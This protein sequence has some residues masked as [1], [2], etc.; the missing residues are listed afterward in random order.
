[1]KEY[2]RLI[3]INCTH[4]LRA[5]LDC[6]LKICPQPSM[7][8]YAEMSTD[9]C[10]ICMMHREDGLCALQAELGEESLPEVC[11]LYPRNV[12]RLTDS[13][14]C[15]CSNSCEEVVEL[16]MNCK[17]TLWFEEI[18]LSVDPEFEIDITS[19]KLECCKKSISMIQD[20]SLLLPER[21]INLGNFLCGADFFSN[22][23]PDH[24]SL[25][26]QVLQVFDKYF[27]YSSSISDYCKT[28]QSYFSIEGKEKLSEEDLKTIAEKYLS[29]SEHLEAILPDWQLLFEQLIVNHMFYNNFPYTDPQETVNDAYLSLVITY[30]FL[31]FNILGFMSDKTDLQKLVDFFAAMFRLIEHSDFEYAAV[32]LFKEEKYPV[33]DGI[34][35]LLRIRLSNK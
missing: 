35:Q 31:R 25:A 30:S 28:S 18:T 2:Y 8:C 27:E 6:A 14:E 13:S 15:S 10:G 32:N 1:M 26:F 21:F 12:K 5:K 3:G 7:E 17:E 19:K 24:L 33:Q 23:R 20:R 16:L 4:K 11:R 22:R 9:W 29:A 34:N